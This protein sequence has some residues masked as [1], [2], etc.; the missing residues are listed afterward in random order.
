MS[1]FNKNKEKADRI[2]ILFNTFK[3]KNLKGLP[4]PP[5]TKWLNG[6]IIKT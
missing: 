3:G 1:Q 5:F 2:K 6:K 4:V